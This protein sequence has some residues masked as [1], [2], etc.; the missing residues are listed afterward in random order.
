[1]NSK[2]LQSV[3]DSTSHDILISDHA[4]VLLSLDLNHKIGEHSWGLNNTLLKNEEFCTCLSGK[5][6]LYLSTNDSGDV[7]DS[8]L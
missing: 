5:I 8:T 1:M 7:H 2:L 3:V 4:S 6:E